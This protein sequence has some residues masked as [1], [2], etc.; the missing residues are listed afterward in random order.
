M[1]DWNLRKIPQQG[2]ERLLKEARGYSIAVAG[3][4]LCALLQWAL[5]SVLADTAQYML[6]IPAVM[7]AAVVG[8]VG[9][10]LFS[11]GLGVVTAGVL[12]V[13][14]HGG[15]PLLGHPDDIIRLAVFLVVGSF[16]S[17]LAGSAQAARHDA[18][19]QAQRL[20]GILE[21]AMDAIVTVDEHQKVVQF[22]P[23]AE[24]T[25]HCLAGEALG[26]SIERFIPQPFGCT[27]YEGQRGA[28]PKEARAPTAHQLCSLTAVRADGES[29]PIEASISQLR[30]QGHRLFTFIVRDVTERQRAEAELRSSEEQF[31]AFFDNAGVGTAQLNSEA[32]F[33]RMNDRYC[34]ITGFSREELMGMSP[35]E[36][37]HP[38][39][40][41]RDTEYL[42][43]FLRGDIEVY[44]V[45]KRYVRKDGQVIWVHVTGGRNVT[46]SM[47]TAVLIEDITAR[48]QAQ[49]E[50]EE[51]RRK[52]EEAS[53]AKDHFLA[54]LSHELR[55][56][57]TPVLA[58]IALLQKGHTPPGA[59]PG[60]LELIRRNVELE[61]RLIDDLLDLTRIV[62]GKLE[63]YKRH[64][65][66]CTIIDR[67]VEVCHADMEARGLHFGMDLGTGC[68]VIDADAARLQQVFWNL[69]KNAIKFTPHGGCVG[70]N[71]RPDR[72]SVVVEVKDS[73]IGIDPSA[74]GRIFHAFAQAERSITRQFGGLGLGLTISRALV[75]AHGGTIEAYSQGQGKGS[76]FKV[77]LPLVSTET[78]GIT[79]SGASASE[80]A[81]LAHRS[82]RIL[83]VEDHGDTVE[84]MTRVLE[85]HGHKVQSAGDVA[86]GLEA[87]LQG[88]CD[89]LLSDLGLP[90]RS[91][92]D[93]MQELRSRGSKLPAIALSGYGQE[94][95]IE[96]SRAAGFNAHLVKPVDI[97]RLLETIDKFA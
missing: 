39:D 95:D 83:L 59:V 90:D 94:R 93:L 91:G 50:L 72:A 18:Q 65:E 84:M 19:Q 16:I 33:M 61:S 79:G 76:T 20:A 40:R 12:F 85:L 11:I 38:D 64:V 26:S 21:S 74:L 32:R 9:P 68:Y 17:L 23:A 14:P 69:L 44:D 56:P 88:T 78:T 7:L 30:I 97:D 51:A 45:E 55:T 31:R 36:L 80:T 54:V 62:R 82:L 3:V 57:L 46:G 70:V 22:N 63:L 77:R 75:E 34:E 6:F 53:R 58:G 48:K 5:S 4:A 81:Q 37:S 67:A 41:L 25:F 49:D 2:T 35:T 43:R 73:G 86:A 28:V 1:A 29:F 92:L 8:G 66:L 96:Q 27:G 10:G 87:A 24:R 89:L 15:L 13:G 47:R 42:E 52:A 60:R 71:C